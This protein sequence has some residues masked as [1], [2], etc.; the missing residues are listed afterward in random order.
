MRDGQDGEVFF[1]K[2]IAE[3]GLNR[4]LAGPSRPD[5]NGPLAAKTMLDGPLLLLIGGE[6]A[7]L[8]A[9]PP[10]AIAN[11]LQVQHRLRGPLQ[12]APPGT[13]SAP[14]AGAPVTRRY[15]Q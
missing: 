2:A 11:R 13:L 5:N 7:E 15:P 6:R 9:D 4:R 1:Q 14:R 12:D 10:R 8:A 3:Q